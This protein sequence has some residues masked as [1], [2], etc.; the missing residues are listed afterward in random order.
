[1]ST[2]N[3]RR[4]GS[5]DYSNARIRYKRKIILN[6]MNGTNTIPSL[7]HRYTN[8]N[9]NKNLSYIPTIFNGGDNII[10]LNSDFPVSYSLNEN[11]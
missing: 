1:M 3:S 2:I 10:S 4:V 5:Q 9:D 8:Q 11:K 7:K 6:Q